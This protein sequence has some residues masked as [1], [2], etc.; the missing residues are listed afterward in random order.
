MLSVVNFIDG[1]RVQMLLLLLLKRSVSFLP[2]CRRTMSRFTAHCHFRSRRRWPKLIFIILAFIRSRLLTAT[3][4]RVAIYRQWSRIKR[5]QTK[6]GRHHSASGAFDANAQCKTMLVPGPQL[7]LNY[8]MHGYTT[9]RHTFLFH[10]N[11][12]DNKTVVME[13]NLFKK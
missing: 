11:K 12:N 9:Q 13:K 5:K 10:N 1:K 6:N 7:P 3:F 4:P 2:W 8:W